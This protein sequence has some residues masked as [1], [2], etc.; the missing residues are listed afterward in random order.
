M[1]FFTG[2]KAPSAPI[3]MVISALSFALMSAAVKQAD[4]IPF[5]QKVFFRNF[6]MGILVI[7][8]L[9]LKM[10][11][12]GSARLFFGASA[13]RK[14]L[15]IRSLFGFFGV[16][17]YF[18]SVER[19]HLGDSAMLNKLSAFFVIIL[20]AVF[21]NERIRRYQVPALFAAF[22]GA[23]LIIKPGMN[24][25]IVPAA[26]GLCAALLAAAAY[27][28]IASLR[29]RE[30]SL[31]II[32]WFSAISVL[33][34]LIPMILVW[35]TPNAAELTALIL[36]GVFAAGGQYF[37]TLAYTHGPAGEV[38]IYNYTHV[39]FSVII[40]FI[41]WREIPDLFSFVGAVLI[42]GAAVFL[43][44]KRKRNFNEV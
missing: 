26:A 20:S 16:M 34:S 5:I 41:L 28:I 8:V 38:S 15:L 12:S 42:I 40:G 2:I 22:A 24:M 25:Q 10:R 21:L 44:L 3:F 36:T 27:T 19:L 23:V 14:R 9:F 4:Q 7:P 18:Y 35:T 39:V 6:V 37:L 32:F 13:N 29:G 17:L 43:Y 31:T 33:M 11:S 1:S 30:D